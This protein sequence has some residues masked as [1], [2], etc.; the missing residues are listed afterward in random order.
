MPITL[1]L[2]TFIQKRHQ[3]I[4]ATRYTST[5]KQKIIEDLARLSGSGSI[6]ERDGQLL[7][8]LRE[9]NVLSLDQISRLFWTN[10]KSAKET[11]WNRLRKLLN[12]HLTGYVYVP[13]ES[14]ETLGLD[15]G[16]IYTL[17]LGGWLWLREE[18]TA[19]MISRHLEPEI[20][21]HDL[22]VAELYV[23]F[24]EAA[25]MRGPN[26]RVVWTGNHT[27]AHFFKGIMLLARREGE[28][29]NGSAAPRK[30]GD[31]LRPVKAVE[32]NDTPDSLVIL[33]LRHETGLSALP[34]F[35]ELD[36]GTESELSWHQK[37]DCYGRFAADEAEWRKHPQLANLGS[38]PIL[39][40]VT[41]D[42]EERLQ[43]LR[44]MTKKHRGD[45]V[46]YYLATWQDLIRGN[47]QDILAA[48]AWLKITPDGNTAGMEPPNRLP[49]LAPREQS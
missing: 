45:G 42:G 46:G 27:A 1:Q 26:W 29:A 18:A 13:T 4:Y 21:M 37:F 16:F 34:M 43:E 11:A 24:L 32:A 19:A 3:K 41:T 44:K 10:L 8:A 48:P 2:G 15:T 36:R 49:M 28:T 20:V 39:A 17:G 7:E 38:F 5:E 22:C 31:T 25:A 40:I 9:L 12:Y 30:D 14:L 35:I 47:N 6:T 33:Q 23:R